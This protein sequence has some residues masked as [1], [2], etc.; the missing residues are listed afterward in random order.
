M[1]P[2]VIAHR[3]ASGDEPENTLR[4]FELALR[5]GAQM[6]EL[7]LYLTSDGHAVVTH[8]DDLTV[9]TDRRGFITQLTL[10]EIRQADAGRGERIPTL[11]ETLDL[12]RGRAALYLEI[13]DPRVAA[14]TIRLV[15]AS[16]MKQDCLIASFELGLMRRLG[17]EITDLELGLIIGTDSYNPVVRLREALPWIAFRQFNYQVLSVERRLCRRRLVEAIHERNKRLYVW[18]ANKPADYRR[19]I[20]QG[21][22]G[23]VTDYPDRLIAALNVQDYNPADIA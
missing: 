6:I 20:A 10:A 2:R 19:L 12:A 16:G 11:V 3:G 21:V 4:A 23:I 7:D 15:R 17:D 22:D 14:E 9:R 8:D 5:Q 13:K 18:T 1:K